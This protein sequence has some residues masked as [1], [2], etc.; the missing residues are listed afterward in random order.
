LPRLTLRPDF[1]FVYA[2]PS[3]TAHP[4][5][6]TGTWTLTKNQLVL[7]SAAQA[8]PMKWTIDPSGQCLATRQGFCFTRLC[9]L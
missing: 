8:K 9:Q 5:E 7:T 2:N 1:T 6:L 3:G 4:Q